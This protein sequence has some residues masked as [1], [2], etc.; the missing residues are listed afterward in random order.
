[1]SGYG[2]RLQLFTIGSDVLLPFGPRLPALFLGAPPPWA[3]ARSSLLLP[4]DLTV[5]AEEPEE[6]LV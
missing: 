5:G 1:M 6:A 3:P 2:V 4:S